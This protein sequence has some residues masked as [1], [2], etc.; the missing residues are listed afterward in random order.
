MQDL[1]KERP[2]AARATVKAKVRQNGRYHADDTSRFAVTIAASP[3]EVYAFFRDF[4]NLPT[5]MKG[6]KEVRVTSSKKSHWVVELKNG[7]STE[8]DAEITSEREG[9]MISWRSLPGSD[10]ETSGTVWF[11]P[12]PAGRGTVVGLEMESKVP[13]GA[14]T[15]L[16]AKFTGEDPDSLTFINL[17]RL[18]AM[19]ETGEVATIEGQP[20]G[21]EEGAEMI[22]KH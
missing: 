18:K 1:K 21:R 4:S 13:G 20:S 16:L 10:V 19:I 22:I 14:L 3:A 2:A 11:S 15:E 8:W 5:F 9:E 12:A 7:L 6:L 17:K